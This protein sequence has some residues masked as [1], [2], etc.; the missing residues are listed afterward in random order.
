MNVEVDI[1]FQCGDCDETIPEENTILRCSECDEK[2]IAQDTLKDAIKEAVQQS[3][4]WTH[5][6]DYCGF[7]SEKELET[8]LHGVQKGYYDA[9]FEIC[10]HFGI[11]EFFETLEFEK[12][13]WNKEKS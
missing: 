7:D 11:I 12:A 6:E 8:F 3:W 5:K 13:D 9:L 4:L 1:K 2:Y 10:D